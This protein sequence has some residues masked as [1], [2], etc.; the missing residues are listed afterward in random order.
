MRGLWLLALSAV[1]APV[2]AQ[3]SGARC[4]TTDTIAVRREL[5]EADQAFSAAYVA[6]NY[7][8]IAD[9]YTTDGALIP[10]TRFVRGRAD[11][12]RFFTRGPTVKL[13][14]HELTMEDLRIDGCAAYEVGMW[15]STVQRGEAPATTST[16]RYI[17][18]WQK[19]SNGK[20]LIRYDIWHN[21]PQQS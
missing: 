16:G 4:A 7:Q 9:M 12:A 10:E 18:I 6:G 20:W 13:V 21:P 11:I 14:A 19:Q 3:Q 8:A 2:A 5:S 1:A 15:K 17:L